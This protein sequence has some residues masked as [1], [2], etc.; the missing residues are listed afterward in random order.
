M[1][2]RL[3]LSRQLNNIAIKINVLEVASGYRSVAVLAG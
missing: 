1:K 3:E 2:H